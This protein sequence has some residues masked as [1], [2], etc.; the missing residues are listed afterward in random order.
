VSEQ[1]ETSTR[2]RR[3]NVEPSADETANNPALAEQQE[4]DPQRQEKVDGQPAPDTA[5]GDSN[6]GQWSGAAERGPL[7]P[8]QYDDDGWGDTPALMRPND[9]R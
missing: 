7:S 4:Q 1:P 8:A 2:R 5:A 3:K 9:G 6:T